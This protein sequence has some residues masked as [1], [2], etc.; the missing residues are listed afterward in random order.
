MDPLERTDADLLTAHCTRS[1]PAAFA[2]LRARYLNLVFAAALRQS[3][4]AH[5]AEDVAQAVFLLVSERAQTLRHRNS[6][7]AGWL[8]LTTRNVARNARRLE[9]RIKQREQKAAAMRPESAPPESASTAIDVSRLATVIDHAMAELSPPDRDL[10]AERFFRARSVSQV[11]TTLQ[12]NESAAGKRIARALARLRSAL[13]GL[14]ITTTDAALAIGLP[15]AVASPPVPAALS[16][17]P[18]SASASAARL[19]QS[20][21]SAAR[22]PLTLGVAAALALSAVAVVLPL[23]FG[24]SSAPSQSAA[25]P[26]AQPVSQSPDNGSVTLHLIDPATKAPIQNATVSIIDNNSVRPPVPTGSDGTFT[27]P[28]P[29]PLT[30]LRT[31]CRAPGHVP[32]EMNFTEGTFRGDRPR[33]YTIPMEAGTRIGGMVTD[34]AGT[35]LAGVSVRISN[36]LSGS[37][38]VPQLALSDQITGAGGR[39][40]FDLAPTDLHSLMIEMRNG[41]S[42]WVRP[43]VTLPPA[44]LRDGSL[45][46]R[47]TEHPGRTFDGAVTDLSGMPVADAVI[48]FA[49]DR[50]EQNKPA[51]RTAS[52]GTFHVGPVAGFEGETIATVT[53]SGFAPQQQHIDE[54]TPAHLRFRLLPAAILSGT[55][56]DSTGQP[57]EGARVEVERW[58]DNRALSWSTRTDADGKFVWHDAPLNQVQLNVLDDDFAPIQGAVATAA[59]PVRLV[60][61]PPVLVQGAITDADSHAPIDSFKMFYGIRWTGQTDVV[62]QTQDS[63]TLTGGKYTAAISSFSNGGKIRVEADGYQPSISRLIQGDEENITLDFALHKGSGPSGVVLSPAGVPL[64]GVRVIC[65]PA[66][67]GVVLEP[68]SEDHIGE[69]PNLRLAFTNSDGQFQAPAF[70]TPSVPYQVIVDS[71]Q[72]FG[73]IADTALAAA[74]R[75]L[76]LRPWSTLRGTFH[77]NASPAANASLSIDATWAVQGGAQIDIQRQTTTDTGGHFVFDNVPPDISCRLWQNVPL[78]ARSTRFVTIGSAQVAAGQTQTSSFGGIGRPVIGT[79]AFPP[80]MSPDA[81]IDI[82]SQ[83]GGRAAAILRSILGSSVPPGIE[84]VAFPDRTFRADDVLPGTYELSIKFSTPFTPG[85]PPVQLADGAAELVV[86]A[87]PPCPTDV[88]LNLGQIQMHA[89]GK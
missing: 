55:V 43:D 45:V 41:Q 13:A 35:P 75:Q 18:A 1:E 49:E 58:N 69:W 70:D 19:A 87:V 24:R 77:R 53:A 50:Y 62:W 82:R 60:L 7:L 80:G 34:S 9:R 65:V 21:S 84:F 67:T 29:R 54:T 32:M 88:P 3:T 22:L 23:L 83:S 38:D 36:Y 47:L 52:D 2:A 42:A 57:V 48:I 86:P 8:L 76:R 33:D 28:L 6:P 39:W 4:D 11:A 79:I 71:P 64:A 12:I 56:V 5:R 30:F 85:H 66:A 14:G 16:S 44:A 17:T 46:Q 81:Q 27:F 25:A 68:A 26:N 59:A 61:H 74:G 89:T 20:T 31:V 73:V 15:A 37:M 51:A 63:Q 40:H 72:G 78:S 10:L